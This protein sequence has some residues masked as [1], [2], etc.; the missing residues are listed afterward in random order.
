[1]EVKE[2]TFDYHDFKHV[3]NLANI[4]ID[5]VYFGAET[6]ADGKNISIYIYWIGPA[7]AFNYYQQLP[8]RLSSL[9]I[10]IKGKWYP[11]DEAAPD[12]YFYD[13]IIDW[14]KRQTHVKCRYYVEGTGAGGIGDS[15]YQ[16]S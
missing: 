14:L 10:E 6:T 4:A 9:W 11:I 7:N 8:E 3:L 12:G 13:E 15:D 2:L 5:D 1:M 16:Y